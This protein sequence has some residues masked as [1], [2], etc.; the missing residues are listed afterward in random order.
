MSKQA[1]DPNKFS[2]LLLQAIYRYTGLIDSGQHKK[3]K[4]MKFLSF[5]SILAL[6][7]ITLFSSCNNDGD[8]AR[9]AAVES[10][11][12][13]P[14]GDAATPAPPTAE[15]PQN[16]SGVWHYT[17]PNGCEG[18]AGSAVA[19]AKCGTTLAHNTAYHANAGDSGSPLIQNAG[20]AA[21]PQPITPAATP[22]PEPPQNAKGV[23]H[24]TCPSGCAGGA[25]SAVPCSKC[26]KTLAHNSAYHQ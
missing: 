23:W 20:D 2:F 15:P 6:C 5:L 13:P 12:T 8:A 22:T 10:V 19:C 26:G 24:Y 25:G 18:G 1:F 17:C 21:V 7:A 3:F 16:S 4:K 14:A 11:T 9:D